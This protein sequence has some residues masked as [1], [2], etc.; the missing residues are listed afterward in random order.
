MGIWPSPSPATLFQS[1]AADFMPAGVDCNTSW[2]SVL[3]TPG[4]FVAQRSTGTLLKVIAAAEFGLLAW[5]LLLRSGGAHCD[6]HLQLRS[7]SVH[8]DHALAVEAIAHCDL[9]LASA[10]VPQ[11]FQILCLVVSAGSVAALLVERFF[12][13]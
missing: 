12:C 10:V 8:S 2:L 1:A 3:A 4:A 7:S 6:L 9:A 11:A 13:E 5:R